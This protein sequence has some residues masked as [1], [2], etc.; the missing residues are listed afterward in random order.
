DCTPALTIN[1]TGYVGS[2]VIPKKVFVYILQ[3]A[4]TVMA[5]SNSDWPA[6]EHIRVANLLLKSAATTG[7]DGGA[8][9]NRNWNDYAFGSDSQGHLTH[10]ENRIR[11]EPTQWNSGVALTLKNSAGAELTTGNS[12]TA[13]EIVTTVGTA[14]QLHKHTFPAFD[15]YTV[16]TDDIHIVNQP[17][18][19][20]GA[21]ETTVD[22]VSDITHYDDGTATGVAIGTNKY[23]NLVL[24]GVQNHSGEPSHIMINL[25]TSQ[26]TNQANALADINGTSVFDIPALFKGMGFLIA[27]LTFRLI[28]GAQWTYIAQEDLRGQIP[29]ISAGVG[30]TTTDHA[31]LANLIAPADD[32]TQYLLADGTRALA[33]AWNMGSQILTNVN[34]DS[35][36][37]HNDVTHTQWD[38]AYSHSLL[39]SGN[40][41]SVTPT[42]LSLVIGTNTQAWD[43]SLDSIAALTYASDS[44]IKV[45]AEDTYAIRTIA[46]T[47]DDLE[48]AIDHDQLANYDANKHIDHTG[49]TLTAGSGITGGGDISTGRSFDLDINSLSVATIAAGD[50]VPFW[51]ITATATNKKI[52]FA[53]F[54]GTLNH[55]ALINYASNEH[56]TQANITATGTISSG[57]WQGTTIAV[58]QGGTGQTTEQAAIDAL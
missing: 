31:L 6:T 12:S 34:I 14:Y 3:S 17:T 52:T 25:P 27:R 56:F 41:H 50:F 36:D 10:I 54:E 22:L 49:V 48:G 39:S 30:V 38:A 46:E 55:D 24:W 2:D 58:N 26:Y 15:M 40:P 11:Q 28:A 8:L 29:P 20:G 9:A 57:T 18:D 21:Y 53:N 13:V 16:G 45:T 51:D 44:F 7:T 32:H 33:G 1:L 37:I 4:K 5:A 42:E 23:F 43:A 19:E 47:A 35:G